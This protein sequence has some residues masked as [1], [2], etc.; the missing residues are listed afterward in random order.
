MAI[1]SLFRVYYLSVF[2]I[3]NSIHRDYWKY[4]VY[5]AEA[6]PGEVYGALISGFFLLLTAF[7]AYKYGLQAY[8][9]QREHE[10]ILKRY[11]EG[12]IDLALN[13]VYK[14]NDMYF[15]NYFLVKQS[16]SALE[17]SG[18]ENQSFEI[19]REILKADFSSLYKV[20]HLLGDD[21]VGFCLMG[22]YAYVKAQSDFYD[23]GFRKLI[24]EAEQNPQEMG[25]GKA[26]A[27]FINYLKKTLEEDFSRFGEYMFIEKDLHR[28]ISILE[29]E[30][31]LTWAKV[32]KFK[33]RDDIVQ[34]VESMKEGSEKMKERQPFD[35][36]GAANGMEVP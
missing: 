32:D 8:F 16:L 20:S 33:N 10:Q 2:F 21:I 3:S 35:I 31:E 23:N 9:R 27:E 29:K 18:S 36:Q 22:L 5:L 4:V 12:G 26:R 19:K 6:I 25:N 34:I 17:I 11:L 14:A 7:L 24:K 13:H 1:I 28:V 15:K 30:K